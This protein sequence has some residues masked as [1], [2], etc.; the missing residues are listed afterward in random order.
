MHPSRAFKCRSFSTYG[1]QAPRL[2][3]S[4]LISL[5]SLSFV[6]SPHIKDGANQPRPPV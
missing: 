5:P 4:L 6:V 2:L 1:T 3:F